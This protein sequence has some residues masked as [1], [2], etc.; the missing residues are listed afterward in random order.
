MAAHTW[1]LVCGAIVLSA[2]AASAQDLANCKYAG[3]DFSSLANAGPDAGNMWISYAVDGS[4]SG[5]IYNICSKVTLFFTEPCGAESAVCEIASPTGETTYTS[6]GTLASMKWS[7]HP[8]GIKKGAVASFSKGEKDA[9]ADI[10]FECDPAATAGRISGA[11]MKNNNVKFILYTELAC[12]G[13]LPKGAGG[14]SLG[15]V[16]LIVCACTIGA[17]FLG[18]FAFK[19]VHQGARGVEAIPN[20]E[21]WIDFP[22]LVKDGFSFSVGKCTGGRAGYGAV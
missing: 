18:G 17:Y 11:T 4:T 2:L 15:S 3:M 10:T 14:L 6:F 16:L 20:S 13:K 1:I 9:S 12:H 7:P 8:D 22:A 19:T 21:F 5:Y